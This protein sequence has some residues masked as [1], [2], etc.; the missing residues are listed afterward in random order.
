MNEFEPQQS[1][2][3]PL[4]LTELIQFKPHNIALLFC[5]YLNSV[6]IKAQVRTEQ[7]GYTI[8]CDANLWQQ[9]KAICDEFIQNPHH[10]KYQQAA[11]QS[12]NTKQVESHA[13][14][15]EFTFVN[16]FLK[17]AGAVTLT[18]FITC[19]LA[20]I[21]SVLGWWRETYS[22]LRFYSQ[23]SFDAFF[24]EPHRLIGPALFHFSLL[25]IAFNTMWW[26]QLG[27]SVERLLGKATLVTLFL[28]SALISNLGQFLV[29][30]PNFGGLSGVVYALV[31][32]V[33]WY[34]WL[35]PKQQLML[36]KSLVGFMLF[37]LLLG[38][39]DLLPMEMANT[40]HLLGLIT[41]CAMA[42]YLVNHNKVR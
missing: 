6:G 11:W 29:S 25:H 2:V 18:V 36:P 34:G 31:G 32:F 7:V 9:A 12:N 8:L 14:S 24:A 26:W 37:W 10:P 15:K 5:D 41:G 35:N 13:G 23:L 39:T 27:G 19:W 33:W 22:A 42:W 17:H 38:F 4:E 30:G 3:P 1:S 28:L 16:Q 21:A 40:A 20:Y